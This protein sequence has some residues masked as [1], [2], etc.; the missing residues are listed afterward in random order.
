MSC[1][2]RAPTR[3]PAWVCGRVSGGVSSGGGVTNKPVR[4]TA[5]TVVAKPGSE[6]AGKY[7]GRGDERHMDRTGWNVRSLPPVGGE[8]QVHGVVVELRLAAQVRVDQAPDG[9]RAVCMH[10]MA[11]SQL[12]HVS[13]SLVS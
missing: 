2:R 6:G 1:R 4:S 13:C 9:R 11:Q 10:A 3:W 12:V 7:K 5:G 8:E